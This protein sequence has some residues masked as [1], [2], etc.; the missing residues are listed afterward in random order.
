MYPQAYAHPPKCADQITYLIYPADEYTYLKYELR[1]LL[2]DN[3]YSADVYV[4]FIRSKI[5]RFSKF[6]LRICVCL[7]IMRIELRMD[8][9]AYGSYGSLRML[10]DFYP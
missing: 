6:P 9:D 8:T 4:Y 2:I 5:L 3:V 1:I 7:R 10:T